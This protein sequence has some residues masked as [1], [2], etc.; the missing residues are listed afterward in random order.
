[1]RPLPRPRLRRTRCC[2][3]HVRVSAECTCIPARAIPVTPSSSRQ[4]VRRLLSPSAA[5]P[6]SHARR[7]RRPLAP[8]DPILKLCGHS[9]LIET[10]SVGCASCVPV[11]RKDSYVWVYTT[12]AKIAETIKLYRMQ[13]CSMDA[14]GWSSQDGEQWRTLALA[15]A[16]AA[17]AA[18]ALLR[19]ARRRNGSERDSSAALLLARQQWSKPAPYI[20][21]WCAPLAAARHHS[22]P[23]ACAGAGP[24]AARSGGRAP[25]RGVSCAAC[26]PLAR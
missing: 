24:G 10:T 3:C 22:A 18:L 8:Q 13:S 20:R 23:R 11:S 1:M 21:C 9:A 15:A 26:R 19:P 17:R 14:G 25:R 5:G 12:R 4:E 7:E 16:R 2:C 6:H